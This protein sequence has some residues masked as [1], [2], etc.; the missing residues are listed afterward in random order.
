MIIIIIIKIIIF[1]IIAFVVVVVV[2][3]ICGKNVYFII[4]GKYTYQHTFSSLD[5]LGIHVPQLVQTCFS[6]EHTNWFL[7]QKQQVCLNNIKSVGK[8]NAGKT[9]TLKHQNYNCMYQN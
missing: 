5:M 3:I 2:S 1:I 9:E 4:S 8:Q 7:F 6:I